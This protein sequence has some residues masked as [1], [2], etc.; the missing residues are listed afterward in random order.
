M[1]KYSHTDESIVAVAALC[2]SRNQQQAMVQWAPCVQPGWQLCIQKLSG[3]K[4]F[5]MGK[6]SP[7]DLQ[8]FGLD[9]QRPCEYC[10][11]PATST[12]QNCK[13]CTICDRWYHTTC[14]QKVHGKAPDATAETYTCKECQEKHY[15]ADSL[16]DDLK[17]YKVEWC[18]APEAIPTIRNSATPQA[19]REL[20][21]LLASQYAEAGTAPKKQ[22]T[23]TQPR[24]RA[25]PSDAERVY[26]VTIGQS[27]RK[28]LVLHTLPI[29]PHADIAPNV[30]GG[31]GCRM[32]IRPVEYT[33]ATGQIRS[34][35]L[36]CIYGT[37][38][39]S[40]T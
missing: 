22:R 16:P 34:K 1:E 27:I 9:T 28:K 21:E 12:E 10:A 36:C 17:L 6:A 7:L 5:R 33:T 26:D 25:T 14:I 40:N 39:R 18:E 11:E 30:H 29:N 8:Q 2:S 20:D 15:T 38:G 4:V 3:Y 19:L 37:D 13:T 32:Y 24:P 23:A 31:G 35:E